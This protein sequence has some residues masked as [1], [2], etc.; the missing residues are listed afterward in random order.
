[1]HSGC[2][3]KT[4]FPK[5]QFFKT[6]PLKM[7]IVYRGNALDRE[8]NMLPKHQILAYSGELYNYVCEHRCQCYCDN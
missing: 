1:M 2:L 5:N 4:N 3:A 7:R 8:H 6:D